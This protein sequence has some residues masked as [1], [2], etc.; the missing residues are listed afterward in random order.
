MNNEV[1]THRT[2]NTK[3]LIFLLI[4]C[5]H[6]NYTNEKI[7]LLFFFLFLPPFFGKEFHKLNKTKNISS[8]R[9]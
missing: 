4:Y 7:T 5:F 9:N 2:L 8:I 6:S 1:V 3:N